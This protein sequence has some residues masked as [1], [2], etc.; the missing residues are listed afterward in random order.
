MREE[1][2]F[3]ISGT[4]STCNFQITDDLWLCAVDKNQISQVLNNIVLNA[5][6]AMPEGGVIEIKAE[7]YLEGGEC[8]ITK[9]RRLC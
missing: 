2:N 8:V 9:T 3:A 1:T 6:Q 7:M 5:T 4:K